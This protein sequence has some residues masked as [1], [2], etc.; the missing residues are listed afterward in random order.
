METTEVS[1]W[2]RCSGF[3]GSHEHRS[4][5]GEHLGNDQ[6]QH[7]DEAADGLQSRTLAG[8]EKDHHR[9]RRHRVH[10]A[11][12]TAEQAA[13]DQMRNASRRGGAPVGYLDEVS[14]I[15]SSAVLYF[16]LWCNGP[17]AQS[18]MWNDFATSLGSDQGRVALK[19]FERLYGLIFMHRRRQL[20][21]HDVAC[22]CLGGDEAIFANF[23]AA[24]T[25]G[26][27][28][29]AMLMASL[30]VRSDIAVTLTDL[31]QQF[32][33]AIRRINNHS[34]LPVHQTVQSSHQLH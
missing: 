34:A 17:A 23:I 19:A 8:I 20:M 26:D 27:R 2:I 11:S 24:A 22:R 21:R 9:P 6:E 29:D 30:L 15:E 4:F 10:A 16:R 1:F 5:A 28:E 13:V 7:R 12:D 25:R 14:D 33:L 31:A 32:G 3:G 18:Q